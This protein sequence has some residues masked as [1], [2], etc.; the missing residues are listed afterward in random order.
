MNG[1]VGRF[2]R[3]EWIVIRHDA[4]IL[5]ITKTLAE[6]DGLFFPITSRNPDLIGEF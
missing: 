1:G 6:G 4:F 5:A 2:E 3:A